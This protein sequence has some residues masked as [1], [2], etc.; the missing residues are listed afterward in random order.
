MESGCKVL[1]LGPP[2]IICRGE[3]WL[4]PTNRG[5]AL[6][7]YL[8]NKKEGETRQK[9]INILWDITES[10]G[11][12]RL[13]QE[14][15]RLHTGPIKKHL[16]TNRERVRLDG[17]MS[18]TTEFLRHLDSG[19]W[20]KAIA[21][22]R[23]GYMEGF[24]L[25][26]VEPFE[27]WLL[28]ERET[29]CNR[30]ILVVSRRAL[31]REAAGDLDAAATDW[32]SVLKCDPLHE[33]ATKQLIRVLSV[34][35]NWPEIEEVI[36]AYRNRIQNELS[37]PPDAEIIRLYERLKRR[38]P[39]LQPTRAPLPIVLQSPP[40]VGRKQILNTIE[41]C[42]RPI[43]ISGE[44]GSGKSRLAREMALLLDG[45][46]TV[47]HAAA[48]ASLPYA[49]ITRT[50]ENKI[51]TNIDLQVEQVWLREAGRLLPHILPSA[52]YPITNATEQARFIEGVARTLIY[53]AGPLLIWEDLQWTDQP[54]LE[55]LSLL[56][57]LAPQLG[58]RLIITMRIPLADSAV[59]DWYKSCL[60]DGGLLQ[61]ELP[62]L[63]KHDVQQL[64]KKLAHQDS[65]AELFAQRLH[66]ATGGNP[67]FIIETLRHLFASGELRQGPQGWAT[68]YDK[69]TRD[70]HEL[71]LP[72]SVREALRVRISPLDNQLRRSLQLVALAQE[73]VT[74][75]DL[76]LVLGI[77]ELEA[78]LH[79]EALQEL[80]LVRARDGGF[81]TA[82]DH[83]RQ[84]LL[85][86]QPASLP[87]YHRAWARAQ[88]ARGQL[89]LSA[90]HWLAAGDKVRG[91][92]SLLEAAR[93]AAPRAT[94]SS[95]ALYERALKL[96]E[97][98]LP[99]YKYEARL[100]YLELRLRLGRLSSLDLQQLQ[101]MADEYDPRPYLLLAEAALQRGEYN[102]ARNNAAL[103]LE[104]AIARR[105]LGQEARAHFI[106]AWIHYRYG[107]PEA[108]L[109]ELEKALTAFE[110]A[111]DISGSARVLRNLAALNYRLGRKEEGDRLQKETMRLAG[112]TDDFVLSLRLRADKTTGMWLRG[113]YIEALDSAERLLLDAKRLGDLGGILDALELVGLSLH[114]LGDDGAAYEY[115]NEFVNLAERFKIEKDLALALSERALP[116]I[117]KKRWN[118]A[119]EDLQ[120]ALKIQKRI[121][122]QAKIGHTY[123][124]YGYLYYRQKKYKLA[125]DWLLRAAAHWRTRKERGHLARSLALAAMAAGALEKKQQALNLSADAV[126]AA[127]NWVVGVPDLPLVYAAHAKIH[128]DKNSADKARELVNMIYFSLKN[129]RRLQFA[130]SFVYSLVSG[131]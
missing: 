91:A 107:D 67:F 97:W 56:I 108:Q 100:E 105:D 106:I 104:L 76:A 75:A 61:L 127:Q 30:Y 119:K 53:L 34:L 12:H 29:W 5:L 1:L 3:Q 78:A 82:H 64:I 68:P 24:G 21:L 52:S 39:P 121:G 109:G 22:W 66:E 98:L 117:E 120:Q 48:T 44:A 57:R 124:T 27:D 4:P 128:N 45:A 36:Y 94:L 122:D 54:S 131:L 37:L 79:L 46:I 49:G 16:I 18:D 86:T 87:T 72:S 43:L 114:K 40:L 125:Q 116:L 15:Y 88:A 35:D 84:L 113:E 112:R 11:R 19:N 70:Y 63:S 73:P 7:A 77:G 69:T 126:E 9:L 103:G 33:E 129:E 50:L 123:Y 93:R 102:Q 110:E 92:A 80:Q 38:Q 25:N 42:R 89:G 14:L 111:E 31:A 99:K 74:A 28:L 10:I 6:I 2:R 17:V 60:L 51:K 130:S 71:P 32:R 13:R 8:L 90:E 58:T 62:P 26:Q 81:A 118:E 83:L 85:E 59:G 101:D 23:G 65:G 41:N 95:L 47:E 55:V 20:N 115:L 96:E